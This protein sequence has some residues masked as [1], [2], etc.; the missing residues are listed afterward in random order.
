[1][2]ARIRVK[3]LYDHRRAY[4]LADK[5]DARFSITHQHSKPTLER[6]AIRVPDFRKL[7]LQFARNIR[8]EFEL[9]RCGCWPFDALFLD[10]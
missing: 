4:S 5:E 3:R 6:S 9:D 7:A 1:M 2:A 10:G 8:T